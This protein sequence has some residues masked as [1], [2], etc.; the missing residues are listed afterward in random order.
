MKLYVGNLPFSVQEQDLKNFFSKY[1]SV[2]SVQLI[3]DRETGRSKGFGFVE[4]SNDDEASNAIQELNGKDL[5]GRAVIVN[6]ARPRENR[7]HREHRSFE[8]RNR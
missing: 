2:K 7:E 8:R 3:S 4:L 5:G 1:S 6:E